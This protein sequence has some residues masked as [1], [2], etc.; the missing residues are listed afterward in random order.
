MNL[1]IE[2]SVSGI[3][4]DFVGTV[5]EA[6]QFINEKLLND[7]DFTKMVVWFGNQRVAEAKKIKIGNKTHLQTWVRK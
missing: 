7:N 2:C 1:F 3:G 4:V 6:L 5:D